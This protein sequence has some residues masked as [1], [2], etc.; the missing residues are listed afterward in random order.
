M[1]VHRRGLYSSALA[2]GSNCEVRRLTVDVETPAPRDFLCE[3]ASKNWADSTC[4]TP[5]STNHPEIFPSISARSINIY[6]NIKNVTQ[7]VPHTE[8]IT[9]ADVGQDDQ[10]STSNALDDSPRDQ[11]I[12]VDT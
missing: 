2:N 9:D 8:Q 11:H 6:H 3:D 1:Q 10:A 7:I 4:Q 12:D 5:C